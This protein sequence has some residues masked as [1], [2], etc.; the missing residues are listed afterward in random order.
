MNKPLTRKTKRL[1]IPNR[2]ARNKVCFTPKPVSV[3][4]VIV[5]DGKPIYCVRYEGRASTMGSYML[6]NTQVPVYRDGD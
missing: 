2:E 6:N 1:C 4:V 5:R 3:D